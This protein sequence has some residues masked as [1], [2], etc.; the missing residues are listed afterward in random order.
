MIPAMTRREAA[1]PPG[2]QT[3][4]PDLALRV[5]LDECVAPTAE[6]T[7]EIT[8]RLGN[9]PV[10]IVALA[11]DRPGT[12]DVVILDHML[13]PS[14][15]L[16]TR[17]RVLHNLALGRGFRSLVHTPETGWTDRVLP[18]VAVRDRPLPVPDPPPK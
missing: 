14:T 15:L 17:D 4:T 18:H 8:R 6:V 1:P 10:D 3:W 5:I 12:P 9:R 16:V 11:S 2:G 13:G 7:A